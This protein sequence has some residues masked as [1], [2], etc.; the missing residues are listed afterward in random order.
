LALEF[1]EGRWLPS[2][3][4][5]LNDAGAG[6][7]RQAIFDTSA[8]DTVDFQAG[9]S[10]TI[11]LTT[12]ELDIDKDLTIAGPGLTAITVS[13]DH[14]SRVFNITAGTVC[15]SG[16][17]IADGQISGRGGGIENAGTLTLSD[18]TLSA[19]SAAT[20]I[21]PPQYGGAIDN[22]GTLTVINCTLTGN[23]VSSEFST[24][25]GGIFNLGT[26]T[27]RDS[28]LSGNSASSGDSGSAVGGG[29]AN[30]G[31]LSV[32]NCT[33][34]DNSTSSVFFGGGG[35]GIC[36]S[37]GTLTLS[38]STLSGNR[39]SSQS[40]AAGGGILNLLGMVMIGNTIVAH[41]TAT[42]SA[43]AAGDLSSQGYNLIG[44]GTGSSGYVG[45]DLVGTAN[46][47][48]DPMLGPLQ[49]NGGPTA[50]MAL[51]PGSP[52]LNA[53]D[54]AQLGVADQRG[55]VRNGGV[56]IGAYQASAR[57]FVLVA[58]PKVTS[59]VPFNMSVTAV[60]PFGQ[61][62]AGYTGTVT[63]ATTDP[64][65]R[66]ILPADYP[67]TA[68]DGGVH[69]FTD[70]GLGETTLWTRGR[71]MVTATNTGDESIVGS[72]RVKVRHAGHAYPSLEGAPNPSVELELQLMQLAVTQSSERPTDG[73]SA[74]SLAVAGSA[75]RAMLLNVG[76]VS[77][78]DR[79]VDGP[80]GGG[81]IS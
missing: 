63:F 80:A 39:A 33:L 27:L 2:T 28:T 18:S 76:E 9:L 54:P 51:L 75:A 16:L 43:D 3:V 10:G 1:L 81:L 32:I 24:F 52:A 66:V 15:I 49:N 44:D 70:T 23:H 77:R 38:N 26:L 61:L 78:M 73:A 48:V 41:N 65:A 7:L 20:F 21:Y 17:T 29:I 25:G 53:G 46:M 59:G 19:N 5:N 55:V 31:T 79:S 62:A 56:N 71:Q 34:S 6:S 45:T 37:S 68:A 30:V 14:A 47:P 4:T 11:T 12:G 36:N 42:S 60:D 8:G 72:V 64:D 69:T 13:G 67:F 35:A 57:A 58:P 50:T 74:L 40:R 22:S